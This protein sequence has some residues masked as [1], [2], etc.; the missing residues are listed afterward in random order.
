MATSFFA[1][2][3]DV[4]SILD[5]VGLMAKTATKKT[6]GV[7]SDDLAVNADQIIGV[8]AERE[9][10]VVWAVTKGSFLNKVI[11]VPLALLLNA[12]FPASIN[13]I[14]LIGGAYLGFE[15][16]EKVWEWFFHRE[17]REE[18]KIQ[19]K[20]ANAAGENLVA[21]EKTKIRKAIKTDFILSA[22]IVVLALGV[23]SEMS[24]SFIML[25]F[26]LSF[27]AAII[28][29]GVYGAVGLIVKLDDI[30]SALIKKY[31][32]VLDLLGRALLWSAPKL[33]RLLAFVGTIAMFAVGGAIWS[34]RLPVLEHA[35]HPMLIKVEHMTGFIGIYLIEIIV[36][37]IVGFSV[38][39]IVAPLHHL[40]EKKHAK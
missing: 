37:V 14:L 15:G 2:F 29:V 31:D 33:L 36:G 19:R 10:P 17:H 4:A 39:A 7:L 24:D 34:E 38:L 30:G 23:I 5:D 12:F 3:D 28:T 20:V 13:Y 11:L 6:A 25:V 21:L 26:A 16:A 32:G 40:K 22:E 9:L 18:M 8:S 1:L 35:L 27:V